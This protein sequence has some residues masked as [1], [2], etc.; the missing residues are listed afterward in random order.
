MGAREEKGVTTA[1]TTCLMPPPVRADPLTPAIVSHLG[2]HTQTARSLLS[3]HLAMMSCGMRVHCVGSTQAA[4]GR[5]PHRYAAWRHTVLRGRRGCRIR[6]MQGDRLSRNTKPERSNFVIFFSL[7]EKVHASV[8]V[9]HRRR[10]EKSEVRRWNMGEA[11]TKTMRGKEIK[12]P[13]RDVFS[14]EE[15]GEIKR[16]FLSDSRCQSHQHNTFWTLSFLH[17]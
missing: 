1:R 10:D 14:K 3:V 2:K 17:Q 11:R 9:P 8:S 15:P 16:E 13:N 4:I 5:I 7:Y 12:K 6:V